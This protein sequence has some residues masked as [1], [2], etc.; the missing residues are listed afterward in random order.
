[1][2]VR[3][4]SR[5]GQY[6][7]VERIGRGG[8][9][10]V[11]RAYHAELDREVAI[12]VLPEFFAEDPEY[13][14]RFRHEARAVARLKHPN[15]LEVFDFG[16]HDGVAYIVMELAEG[17]T[18]AASLGSPMRLDEVLRILEPLAAA[19]D[20]AHSR[21]ILHRDIKPSNIFVRQDGTPVLADFGLARMAGSHPRLTASGVIMGTPEYMSPEQINDEKVGPASDRYSFAVVA[22]E[23]FTGRVPFDAET[24]ASVLISHLTHP[25]PPT[26]ELT[27]ELSAHVEAVLRRALAKSAEDRYQSALSFVL[28]LKPAAWIGRTDSSSLGSPQPD[29]QRGSRHRAT[30]LVVDDAAAN[31]ELIKACLNEVECEVR[32]ADDGVSALAAIEESRP[33]LVLLDVQMPGMDGFEVCHRIKRQDGGALLPVVMITALDQTNDRVRALTS[34]ADD[35]MTKPVDRIELVARVR[36]AL[37]LKRVYDSLDSAEHVIFAL[38]AAVEAKDPFTEAHTERVARTARRVGERMGLSDDDLDA[39]YRGG[40]IHDIGKIGVPDNILLKPG[41]LDPEEQTRMHL[42]PVIGESIVAPL[43]TSSDLLAMIRH[44]H[45]RFDGRGYPDR[46]AGDQIPLLARILSVCDAY[47]ALTNDR[48]YRLRQSHDAAL[49]VLRR[50]AGRQWDPQVVRVVLQEEGRPLFEAQSAT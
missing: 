4:G 47:D 38:A 41:R 49:A 25:I 43:R 8:M 50:G 11:Y 1:M 28:A 22:Y 18:L 46:L 2:S 7:I 36:S 26:P 33:D 20:Y 19:L 32:T 31:R 27:G 30:V 24:P 13:R 44:H 10:A 48:P 16:D 3:P 6:E 21:G 35:F 17:G 15:I 45:E 29:A 37:K 34:G 39:L 14:Q 40:I 42:H 12:K 9:A 23:M 5:L